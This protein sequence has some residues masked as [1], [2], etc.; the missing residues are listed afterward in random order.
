MHTIGEAPNKATI[1]SEMLPLLKKYLKGYK[2]ALNYAFTG[3]TKDVGFNYALSAPQP[4]YVEGLGMEEYRPLR[5]DK[6]VN[7]AVLYED[8]PRSVT[9]PHLAGEWKGPEE[10]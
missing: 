9:L 6:H 7:G 4:D 8:N 1:I 5:T 10:T 2:R 3:F